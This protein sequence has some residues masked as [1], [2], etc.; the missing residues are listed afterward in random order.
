MIKLTIHHT[1]TY[2]FNQSVHLWP[3]RL[4]LRPRESRELRL[5]SHTISATPDASVTWALDVFGN[6]VATASFQT[7]ADRLVIDSV[8][9]V[10]LDSV[11]RSTSMKLAWRK[12]EVDSRV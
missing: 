5:I 11:A 10:E 9:E 8:A 12:S 3:H 2:R 1:T 4:M 7:M 6:T